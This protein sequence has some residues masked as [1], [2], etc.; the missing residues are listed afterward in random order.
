[1]P[2]TTLFAIIAAS[3]LTPALAAKLGTHSADYLMPGCRDFV[4]HSSGS[5][6]ALSSNPFLEGACAGTI[7]ALL[8]VGDF[9]GVCQPEGVTVEQ[10]IRVVIQ[11]IDAEPA[12]M[13][14]GFDALAILALRKAWPCQQ[15]QQN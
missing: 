12:L 15:K 14:E 9:I 11:Y 5:G 7:H 4:T 8:A 3:M 13:H 6:G 10:A 1:M 2:K